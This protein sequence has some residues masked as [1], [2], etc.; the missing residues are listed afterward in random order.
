MVN[1]RTGRRARTILLIALALTITTV[2]PASADESPDDDYAAGVNSD[3]TFVNPYSIPCDGA[4]YA[5]ALPYQTWH[6]EPVGTPKTIDDIGIERTLT[7][8]KSE[9]T[10]QTV[11]SS[12]TVGYKVGAKLT[13]KFNGIRKWFANPSSPGPGLPGPAAGAVVGA[14]SPP[15]ARQHRDPVNGDVTPYVDISGE[16]SHTSTETVSEAKTVGWSESDSFKITPKRRMTAAAKYLRQESF[17]DFWTKSP[18]DGCKPI[19]T[20]KWTYSDMVASMG[21]YLDCGGKLCQPDVDYVDGS[22]PK[23]QALVA[24]P[25]EENVDGPSTAITYPLITRN[26]NLAYEATRECKQNPPFKK[27]L[28]AYQTPK[29]CTAKTEGTLK[30]FPRRGTEWDFVYSCPQPTGQTPGTPRAWRLMGTDDYDGGTPGWDFG[31]KWS[32]FTEDNASHRWSNIA[33]H[34]DD[35]FKDSASKM[36]LMPLY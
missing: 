13:G 6:F 28:C 36:F 4:L 29:M 24:E 2:T 5:V 23:S 10:T 18:S 1:V 25:V 11:S 15:E 34:G 19:K 9:S 12:T 27:T 21:W 30:N 16:W 14:A 26:V 32:K 7:V 8:G 35:I 31:T 33:F 22:K 17:S 3:L 20:N